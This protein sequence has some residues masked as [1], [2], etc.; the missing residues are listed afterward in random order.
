MTESPGDPV[1][2]ARAREGSADAFEELVR[3]HQHRAYALAL[4]LTGHPQ[5]AEDVAQEAFVQAWRSLP[6]FRGEAAFETWLYRIVINRCHNARRAARPTQPMPTPERGPA[7]PGA[8]EVV[9]ARQQREAV[10]LRIAQLPLPQRA[11]L[12]L[13]YF[14]G[15]SYAETGH[16]L[17]VSESA[18]KVRVFRARRQLAEE[19]KGWR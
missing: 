13:H 16:I 4:R 14:A 15:C 10:A 17:G 7:T 12:V 9:E 11:A 18:A 5:D 2:V 6:R 3:R 19:L 8:G 1:L